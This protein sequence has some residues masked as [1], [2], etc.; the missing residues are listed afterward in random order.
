MVELTVKQPRNPAGPGS[1][2]RGRRG[3]L[4]AAALLLL[5]AAAVAQPLEPG[6]LTGVELVETLAPAEVDRIV[7][8]LFEKARMPTAAYPIDCYTLRFQSRYPDDSPAPATAQLFVPRSP[9]PELP[10]VYLFAPGSTGLINSCRPSREHI[11]GI[12]W[13]LYRSHVLAFAGQGLLGVLPDYLGFADPGRLQPYMSSKAEAHLVLDAVRA[14]RR[15]LEGSA[16][17]RLPRGKPPVFVS[18][19]SQG[20]HAA[21]AAA[22]LQRAYAPEAR[23]AG[24]IGY[25]PS[26]DM[27]ALFREFP[28]VA[29]MAIYTYSQLYGTERFDPALILGARWLGSLAHD[30]TRQCVGGMQQY[31]PWSARELFTPDFSDA[32][33]ARRL[34]E[35]YPE[36]HRILQENSPGLT[37]HRVP[38]LILQGTDDVVVT[39]ASQE[40]FVRRLCQ[41]GNPVRY[42]VYH[43]RHDTRQVGFWEAL[44]WIR[45][46]ADGQQAPSDCRELEGRS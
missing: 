10:A 21:F 41:A 8:V 37:R 22:D 3:R 17:G 24:I 4:L 2:G 40:E 20:G 39:P 45:A 19:F 27:Q 12:R 34:E 46:L 44:E 32:L 11:A 38:S 30:V 31:Y 42:V 16:G 23:I 25:G 14:A 36:I 18:G 5:A 1:A 29:P 6:E 35:R 15:F 43:G 33:F 9:A 13:G 7:T 26:T 28:V